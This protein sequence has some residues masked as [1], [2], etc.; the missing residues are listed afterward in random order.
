M[1][2]CIHVPRLYPSIHQW[3]CRWLPCLGHCKQCCG[4]HRV[5]VSFQTMFF[6]GY[7]P[8]GGIAGSFGSS[9]FSLRSLHT[10]A[11]PIYIP[12]C[13]RGPF[14]PHPLQHLLFVDFLMKAILTG[15]R[16]YLPEVLMCI[17]LIISREIT[18]FY[19]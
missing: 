3:T 1:F 13:R 6:S 5:R 14:S 9:V 7:A 12:W 19:F 2:H 16:C 17:S 4:E 8:Q 15:V 11:A 18:K 10:V